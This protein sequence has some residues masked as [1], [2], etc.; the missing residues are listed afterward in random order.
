MSQVIESTVN[1]VKA[2][3][4]KVDTSAITEPVAKAGRKVYDQAAGGVQWYVERW[5][6][7]VHEAKAARAPAQTLSVEEVLAGL[8]GAKVMSSIPGRARLRL[9]S[10]K[11]QD[12]AAGEVAQAL[13]S[14]PGISQAGVNPY[15][16][17]VLVFFDKAQYPSLDALLQAVKPSQ[18]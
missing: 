16:G 7:M 4:D 1:S 17:S 8:S 12:Q 18:T 2:I 9:K 3:P 11:R 14:L 5:E 10:L 15:T 6:D 13:A